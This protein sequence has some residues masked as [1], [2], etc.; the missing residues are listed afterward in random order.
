MYRNFIDSKSMIIELRNVVEKWKENQSNDL[1]SDVTYQQICRI[2]QQWVEHYVRLDFWNDAPLLELILEIISYL[3]DIASSRL[4]KL[5][6]FKLSECAEQEYR[7]P[8]RKES[9]PILE[10]NPIGDLIS[11]NPLDIAQQITLLEFEMLQEIDPAD[12][13]SSSSRFIFLFF[14]SFF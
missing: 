1:H 9:M 11:I 3:P 6:E 4:K 5:L 13:I 12:C 14:F 10:R 8:K 7:K 2:V